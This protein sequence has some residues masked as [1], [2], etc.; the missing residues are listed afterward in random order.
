LVR[1]ELDAHLAFTHLAVLFQLRL[2]KDLLHRA[3]SSGVGA[4]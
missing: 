4:R 2:A 1:H 3:R